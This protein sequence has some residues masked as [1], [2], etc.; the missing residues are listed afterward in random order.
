M[1]DELQASLTS[2]PNLF[3]IANGD[4]QIQATAADATDGLRSRRLK[5]ATHLSSKRRYEETKSCAAL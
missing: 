3:P 2:T 5:Q 1:Q 4:N